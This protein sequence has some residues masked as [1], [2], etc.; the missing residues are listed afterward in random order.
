[1]AL[2][3]PEVNP[4]FCPPSFRCIYIYNI[5]KYDPAGVAITTYSANGSLGGR[6]RQRRGGEVGCRTAASTIAKAPAWIEYY[7]IIMFHN[8]III[9]MFADDLMISL[10]CV[11]YYVIILYIIFLCC[12]YKRNQNPGKLDN[13]HPVSP[14]HQHET[15]GPHALS[16]LSRLFL[17]Q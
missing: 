15:L 7:I 4:T 12:I 6:L 13:M 2:Q 16:Q 11:R 5:I 10:Q 3:F 9:I 14:S 17:G 8:I 1:V